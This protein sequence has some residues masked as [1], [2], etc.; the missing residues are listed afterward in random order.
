MVPGE[1]NRKTPS[2]AVVLLC[3]SACAVFC[4]AVLCLLSVSRSI[5]FWLKKQARCALIQ[6]TT[7]F[8][9]CSCIIFLNFISNK[10][11]SERQHHPKRRREESSTPTRERRHAVP[12]KRAARAATLFSHFL[13]YFLF[14]FD[15]LQ[16]SNK[17]ILNFISLFC[18]KG[19]TAA[20]KREITTVPPHRTRGSDTHP[21]EGSQGQSPL[22]FN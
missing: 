13:L 10:P 15:S 16:F 21:K 17:I 1:C 12:P 6:H 18:E 8:H 5:N 9:N 11:S 2:V 14:Q 3:S 19:G 20:P 22:Y 4:D 7:C